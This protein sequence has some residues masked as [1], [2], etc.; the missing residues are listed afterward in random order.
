MEE[1]VYPKFTERGRTFVYV[2]PC[3]DEDLLKVGFSRDPLGR[4]RTLHPRFFDFFD[5]ERGL[6]IE[7]DHL[8]DA[9]RIERLFI[10]T[11]RADRSPA[12]LAVRRAAA[13]HT[14]WYR[15]I[16]V[17]VTDMARDVC[18]A[19]GFVLHSPLRPWLQD[20]FSGWA[21]RLFQWSS[22]MLEMVEYDYFN[23]GAGTT[24]S[25]ERR[26]ERV[27]REVLDA[28][29]AFGIDLRAELPDAVSDWYQN[30]GF[31]DRRQ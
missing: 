10:D 6:L 9:R 18:V 4:F 31:F 28:Y 7:V 27:L 22:Q 26:H 11:F 5:L 14:E 16:D 20:R 25:G 3:R 13:G 12:P 21:D 1:E 8:R 29:A 24:G 17:L 19:E 30:E 23:P 2:L 15:G